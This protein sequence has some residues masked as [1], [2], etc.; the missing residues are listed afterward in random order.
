MS[1]Q[2]RYLAYKGT[3]WLAKV[4]RW[5]TQGEYSHIAFVFDD[6]HTI[7]VWPDSYKELLN[8][9][10]KIRKIFD[11]YKEGDEYEIWALDVTTA[12][13]VLIN[14]FFVSLVRKGAKFDYWAGFGLFLKWK[15]EKKNQYF[16]SEGC[17][18]PLIEVFKLDHIVPWKV[19]PDAFVWIIQALG[20]K[21]V[22]K[23][24]IC[25]N[26]PNEEAVNNLTLD[27]AT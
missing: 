23:G 19:T 14:K 17:I 3:D 22:E 15:K 2:I 5:E 27:F 11:G 16:C 12:Q 13:Y 10:W 18:Y 8:C 4:I 26:I 20:A 24:T 7:E 9:R 6:K 21:I 25:K 1:K